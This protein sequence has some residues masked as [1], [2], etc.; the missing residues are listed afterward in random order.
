MKRPTYVYLDL[1]RTLLDTDACMN[2]L[3][4]Q[5]EQLYGLSQDSIRAE[6]PQYYHYLGQ[7][8]YYDFFGQMA[9]HNLDPYQIEQDMIATINQDFL[10]PD[11]H[12]MLRYLTD[13]N[14]RLSILSFGK[15]NFQQLKYK[16]SPQLAHLPFVSVLYPKDRFISEGHTAPSLLIDDVVASNLPDYC[17]QFII[18]RQASEEIKQEDAQHIRIR[19]LQNVEGILAE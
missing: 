8:R 1:D 13:N 15:H 4:D 6:I 16:L 5:C 12:D 9:A 2:A 10:F 19:S 11:A 7:L 17:T 14:Y 18:D 3:L